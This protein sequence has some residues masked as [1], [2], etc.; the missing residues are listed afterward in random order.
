MC[1]LL[2]TRKTRTTLYNPTS[3]G[4]IERLN[5]MILQMLSMFVN[6]YQD[7]WDVHLPFVM[8]AFH[9]SCHDSTKFS[10]FKL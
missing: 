2:E 8:M 4:M 5:R 6:E 7:D 3:D 9:S 1:K 10:Q